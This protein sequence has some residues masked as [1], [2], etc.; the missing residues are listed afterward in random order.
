MDAQGKLIG[1][2]TLITSYSGNYSGVG[3]AIPVNYAVQLAQDIIEGKEPTHAQLGVNLTTV[4]AGIAE[5][6]GFSVD[7]GA[8]VS[9]VSPDSGAE[10]AGIKVGDIIVGFDGKTVSSAS[11]LMLDVRTKNPGDKVTLQVDRDGEQMDVEVTLGQSSGT[12]AS[13]SSSSSSDAQQQRPS[14]PNSSR[15]M[16]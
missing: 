9:A 14:A 16:R 11:D 12:T 1:V 3:F 6:Y 8:Y 10:A 2:N 15:N 7:E 13:S 4:N 5:R